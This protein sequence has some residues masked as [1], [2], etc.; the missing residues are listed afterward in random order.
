VLDIEKIYR[1]RNP[2]SPI[3]PVLQRST[4]PRQINL[5]FLKGWRVLQAL[6]I[7]HQNTKEG[8]NEY[9]HGIEAS[10]VKEVYCSCGVPFCEESL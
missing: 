5:L 6:Y 3:A 1:A 4:T 9:P 7:L 8:G 10:L 2:R